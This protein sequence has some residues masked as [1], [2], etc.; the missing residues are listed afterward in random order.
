MTSSTQSKTGACVGPPYN[1]LIGRSPDKKEGSQGNQ[2]SPHNNLLYEPSTP[3]NPSLITKGGVP[4][5]FSRGVPYMNLLHES[6][7]NNKKRSGFCLFL[8]LFTHY[9]T[10]H[11]DWVEP[12]I[13]NKLPVFR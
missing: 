11:S 12:R 6:I 9:T 5:D 13:N 7:L 4:G 8:F 3:D 1:P 2:G 10:Y